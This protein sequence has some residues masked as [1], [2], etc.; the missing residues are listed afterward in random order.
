MEST[1]FHM[2]AYW[3]WVDWV[4]LGISSLEAVEPL[5][6]QHPRYGELVGRIRDSLQ[7]NQSPYEDDEIVYL[8]AE[9]AGDL[10]AERIANLPNTIEPQGVTNIPTL[11]FS[12]SGLE[13]T[14]NTSITWAAGWM[15]Y[16]SERI[17][18]TGVVIPEAD[19]SFR[20]LTG[21][22]TKT[23]SLSGSSNGRYLVCLVPSAPGG[24]SQTGGAFPLQDLLS[25]LNRI[26]TRRGW[27]E[28]GLTAS[29]FLPGIGG[30]TA[31]LVDAALDED[32]ISALVEV[33]QGA[34]D[35]YFNNVENRIRQAEYE[36]N[37]H[38][39]KIAILQD[40]ITPLDQ[41]ISDPNLR[42]SPTARWKLL[43]E[44]KYKNDIAIVGRKRGK[45]YFTADGRVDQ[46]YT[47]QIGLYVLKQ[48]R[49]HLQH[50]LSREQRAAAEVE[51]RLGRLRGI[52]F[53][54]K[55]LV[56]PVV[57]DALGMVYDTVAYK[58]V[59]A[60]YEVQVGTQGIRYTLGPNMQ[61]TPAQIS[62]GRRNESYTFNIKVLHL[63]QQ[64]AN[65]TLAWN[66]G[67][68]ATGSRNVS[69]S[70][71]LHQESISHAYSSPGAYGATIQLTA[72]TN[73]SSQVVPV[74]IEIPEQSNDYSL[75]ICNVWKA[76]NSGG[77]GVT[78][79]NWDISAIPDGATFN[80]SFDTYSIPDRIFV[81]Y[82][83]GTQVLD[84]GWRGS[85]SYNGNPMY[86]GGISGP[87][88]GQFN[89]IF[90]KLPGQ[91]AFRVTVV[92][93]DRDTAWLYSIRCNTGTS[94]QSLGPIEV[95]PEPEAQ[96]LF[97][98]NPER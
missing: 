8:S 5:V 12:G 74:Y 38:R 6:R 65:F 69:A 86:P 40:R 36:R 61:V 33:N 23:L 90:R 35:L 29:G 3:D 41:E 37:L 18:S 26:A 56:V 93:P 31:G 49:A 55:F 22:S 2:V 39:L 67:D 34:I 57:A 96:R 50:Q 71:S 78:R 97:Q 45:D 89:N 10:V 92:G 85:S 13:V 15:E 88:Q 7:R 21:P 95:P 17:L 84:T 72:G 58:D 80:I 32:L 68:G 11:S 66:F 94:S 43:A 70:R 51:R 75:N 81:E 79:D 62:N 27:V 47:N 59:Y 1:A 53:Y 60:C 19:L 91:N 44:K 46:R 77:Y 64:T 48:E 25:T 87:G 82:P 24:W 73:R 4:R 76:A 14:N 16:E 98:S 30:L 9:I 52:D 28:F 63:T 20:Y 54:G 42:Q 83:V